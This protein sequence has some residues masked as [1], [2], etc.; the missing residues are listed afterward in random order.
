MHLQRFLAEFDFRYNH[1]EALGFDNIT[2][3]IAAVKAG[4]E[5]VLP[6]IKLI[7]GSS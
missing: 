6:I 5:S 3:T 1:R 4:E 7:T 2:P